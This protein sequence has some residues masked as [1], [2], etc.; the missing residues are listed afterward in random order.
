MH[1]RKAT[2]PVDDVIASAFEQPLGG[3]A[4]RDVW[5]ACAPCLARA[6][7]HDDPG[8]FLES[9][10]EV[11]CNA[12]LSGGHEVGALIA[13]LAEGCLAVRRALAAKAGTRAGDA[14][15]RL[16]TLERDGA[17]S[18]ASGYAAGL[19]E[20]IDRLRY[21]TEECSPEDPMSGATRVAGT[22]ELLAVEVDRCRRMALSLGILGVALADEDSSVSR[23]QADDPDLLHVVAEA[24]RGNVRRYDGVGRT[25]DGDFF[26]VLPDVSRRSLAAIAERLRREVV[27]ELGREPMCVIALAHY[28]YAD[29][30]AAE[31]MAAVERSVATSRAG[32]DPVSW[33]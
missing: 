2:G 14:L 4:V 13:G 33:A 17:A 20:T 7:E 8:S 21:Q 24:L 16:T 31:M 29:V 12:A 11:A 25:A 27:G 6:L 26:V 15:S 10:E 19:E 32:R 23:V 5:D 28:D 30:S 9:L 1:A 22:L 18:L 3:P